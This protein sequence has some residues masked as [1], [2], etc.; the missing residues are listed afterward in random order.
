MALL[1]ARRLPFQDASPFA[2]ATKS[3]A[4][5][6]IEAHHCEGFFVQKYSYVTQDNEYQKADNARIGKTGVHVRS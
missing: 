6:K 4:R 2:L 3:Q 1:V 5:L